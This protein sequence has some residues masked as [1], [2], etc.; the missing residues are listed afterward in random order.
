VIRPELAQLSI[1]M[2]FTALDRAG[3]IDPDGMA[4]FDPMYRD[5]SKIRPEGGK[6][7]AGPAVDGIRTLAWL[8]AGLAFVNVLA[9]HAHWAL[10]RVKERSPSA[11][12]VA[13]P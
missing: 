13:G 6:Y 4:T 2:R 12:G 10:R 5:T 1:S 8:G 3:A 9:I 7:L 11:V